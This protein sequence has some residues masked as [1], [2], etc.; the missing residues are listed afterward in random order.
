MSHNLWGFIIS[1]WVC[2]FVQFVCPLF[3]FFSTSAMML[4]PLPAARTT[5]IINISIID[6]IAVM[7]LSHNYPHW[8][9]DGRD[10]KHSEMCGSWTVG[11]LYSTF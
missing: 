10:S 3:V 5:K 8:N 1:G 4:F 2:F 11:F 9:G 7:R 6:K